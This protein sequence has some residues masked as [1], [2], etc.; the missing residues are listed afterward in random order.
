MCAYKHMYM[1]VYM[2]IMIFKLALV[3]RT[4]VC[5]KQCVE[6]PVHSPLGG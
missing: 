5:R 6:L 1:Y 3:A 2:N 4:G